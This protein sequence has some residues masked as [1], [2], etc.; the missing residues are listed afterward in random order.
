MSIHLKFTNRSNN[1]SINFY[2]DENSN[3]IEIINKIKHNYNIC[4]DKEIKIF[5][6]GK[7]KK[8][9]YF[10]TQSEPKE[11][12]SWV[13]CIRAFDVFWK[14]DTHGKQEIDMSSSNGEKVLVGYKRYVTS[15]KDTGGVIIGV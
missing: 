15:D 9:V 5:C 14:Q 12:F 3:M 11:M 7:N 1:T 2:V 6:I 4:M 10:D 13:S 8:P